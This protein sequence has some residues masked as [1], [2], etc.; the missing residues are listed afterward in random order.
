MKPKP[1][2]S[3]SWRA[4]SWSCRKSGARR[5]FG[6]GVTRKPF[7]ARRSAATI[8]VH[9]EA[10]RNIKNAAAR[11]PDIMTTSIRVLYRDAE[12]LAGKTIEVSGWIRTIRDQKQFAFISLND[13]TFF[14]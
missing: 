13:G 10:A 5:S 3:T 11:G 8:R 4:G 2:G 7:G 14:Q 12:T 6:N 9:A 1:T